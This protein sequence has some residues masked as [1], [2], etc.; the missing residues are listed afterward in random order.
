M[1]TVQLIGNLGGNP[2][3][4]TFESGS[5]KVT[6]T[7]YINEHFK[8][9]SGQKTD[10]VHRFSVECWGKT[11]EFAADYL[12]QGSRIAVVGSLTEN[13][14]QSQDGQKHSRVVV[15]AQRLET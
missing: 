15:R 2:E 12:R 6:F 14:W 1:N 13:N 8:N 4:T 11:A 9:K 7:L 3:A 5:F 10:R